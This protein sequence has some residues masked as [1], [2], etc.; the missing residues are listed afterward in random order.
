MKSFTKQSYALFFQGSVSTPDTYN[1][2]EC[3]Q[4]LLHILPVK[5][6]HGV[7][8]AQQHLDVVGS[9]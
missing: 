2:H 1:V 5:L 3:E 9:V 8:D 4:I 7:V 6:D